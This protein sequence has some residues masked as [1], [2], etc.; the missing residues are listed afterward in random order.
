MTNRALKEF[1]LFLALAVGL[2]LAQQ[3][4]AFDPTAIADWR[5]WWLALAGTLVRAAAAAALSWWGARKAAGP[6]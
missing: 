6:A 2:A 4:I 1:A 3:L 5:Y